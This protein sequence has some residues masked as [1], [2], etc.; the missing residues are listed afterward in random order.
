M[1]VGPTSALVIV[2]LAL[3]S[4]SSTRPAHAQ[5][6]CLSGKLEAMARKEAGLLSCLAGVAA[7]GRA[8][9]FPRCIRKVASRFARAYLDAGRCGE[10]RTL[11]ECLTEQCAIAVRLV[12]PD[13][14]P[15]RC[16]AARLRAAGTQA[17]RKVGCSAEAARTGSTVDPA[18]LEKAEAHLRA[19]FARTGRCTGEQTAVEAVVNEECVRGLG[20]DPTGGGTI[21]ALCTSHACDGV[22]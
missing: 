16:E 22:D 10:E 8:A 3:S 4:L 9:G 15:S 19:V 11:C 5:S 7:K 20:A 17:R 6:A 14:G 1:R 2:A 21:G 18:C 13:A 12:L